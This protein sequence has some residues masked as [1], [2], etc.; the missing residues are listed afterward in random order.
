MLYDANENM[1]YVTTADD[2]GKNVGQKHKVRRIIDPPGRSIRRSFDPNS[3]IVL[4]SDKTKLDKGKQRESNAGIV[5]P[6]IKLSDLTQDP[7]I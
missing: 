6:V 5:S 1:I 4:E 2:Q 7:A 3:I